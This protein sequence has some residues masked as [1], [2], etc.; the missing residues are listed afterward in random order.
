M[1]ERTATKESWMDSQ[2]VKD[3][4]QA[5]KR[6]FDRFGIEVP[7]SYF[8]DS[9]HLQERYRAYLLRKRPIYVE[10]QNHDFPLVDMETKDVS[11]AI[12]VEGLEGPEI[13]LNS[14]VFG[15]IFKS[16]PST[17]G[18]SADSIFLFSALSR[19]TVA[20]AAQEIDLPSARSVLDAMSTKLVAE[21]KGYAKQ[22][23]SEKLNDYADEL[24]ERFHNN[25]N[26]RLS[27]KGLRVLLKDAEFVYVPEFAQEDTNALAIIEQHLRH[28]F[29]REMKKKGWFI[30]P[31]RWSQR[32][33]TIYKKRQVY[34]SKDLG[35]LD[36]FLQDYISG[37]LAKR[38]Y[39]FLI[40]EQKAETLPEDTKEPLLTSEEPKDQML[41]AVN[42]HMTQSNVKMVEAPKKQ[43]VKNKKERKS[44]IYP[45][46][47]KAAIWA[48]Q[49]APYL[50]DALKIINTMKKMSLTQYEI[51]K[52][53]GLFSRLPKRV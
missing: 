38:K 11:A 47:R 53:R 4:L 33:K 41:K 17:E 14:E 20:T 3:V 49:Q 34:V 28:L 44:K 15:M 27:A 29:I 21:L 52:V 23:G 32:V 42:G 40:E 51:L 39:A 25:Q 45:K 48:E 37:D 12:K 16:N 1:I 10:F 36:I 6:V 18:F 26:L 2:Q 31:E 7:P 5:T 13:F 43:N 8:E 46:Q 9:S 24:S 30:P 19:L 22:Q 50:N 35:D